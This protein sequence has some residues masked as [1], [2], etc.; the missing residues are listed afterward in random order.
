M[1]TRTII[2]DGKKVKFVKLPKLGY[3]VENDPIVQDYLRDKKNFVKKWREFEKKYYK[4][5][6][7]V[8]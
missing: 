6:Y 1:R 2:I 3:V 5:V 8:V 7:K 4:S